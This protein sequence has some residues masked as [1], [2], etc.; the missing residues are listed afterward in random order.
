MNAVVGGDDDDDD[1]DNDVVL[2]Y[3]ALAYDFDWDI[4]S[5]MA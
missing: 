1:D 5:T 4:I 2:E 3:V